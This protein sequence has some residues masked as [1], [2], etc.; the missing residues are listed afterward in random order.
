MAITG[1]LNNGTLRVL[2]GRCPNLL[3][4]ASLYQ[5]DPE[6]GSEKP[7]AENNHALDALRYLISRIDARKMARAQKV[8]QPVEEAPAKPKEP[9][10]YKGRTFR[11][12]VEDDSL[13]TPIS[14]DDLWR[15]KRAG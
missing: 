2:E 1:R 5:Y 4:E 6:R 11:E 3:A 14:F 13:W 7:V 9:I 8:D 12:F 10:Y 15:I